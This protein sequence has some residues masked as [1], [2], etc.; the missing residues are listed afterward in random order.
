MNVI[1]SLKTLLVLVLASALPAQILYVGSYT[2]P[3]SKGITAFRFDASTGKLSSMGLMAQ[4]ES[5]SFLAIHPSG[6]FLYAVN[7]TDSY[8]GKPGGAITA[9]AIDPAN[10][11]LTKLNQVASKGAAPCHIE[12]DVSGRV[13]LVANYNGGNFAS[14][15]ILPDGKLGEAVTVIQDKG[16]GPN[17]DR[18]EGPH[19]HQMVIADNLVLGADLGTDHI[20]LFHVEPSSAVLTPANPPFAA[21]DPGFGPRHMVISNDKKH[22]YVLSELKS[23]V[24]TMEYDPVRGP[25]KVI[26]TV[27]ALPS[28]FKGETTA[29]EIMLDKSGHTLYTSNRGHDSIAVFAVDP[30][31]GVPSLTANVSSG[32][33]RRDFLLWTPRASTFWRPTRIPTTSQF[34]A[35]TQ[36]PER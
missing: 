17:K 8:K 25:G 32:G 33:K 31:T 29:A 3:N 4:T 2:G 13:A 7:E 10:G 1:N 14:F 6:K 19:A 24:A 30:K 12:I 26:S 18:Q 27:S 23:S 15:P 20:Q 5:P 35:L 16:K 36:K 22:V 21:T 34:F 9:F 11:K 28:G